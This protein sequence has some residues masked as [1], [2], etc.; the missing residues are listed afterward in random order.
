MNTTV[1]YPHI[2]VKL[3]GADG[4]A[5]SI[6]GRVMSALRRGDVLFEE[7]IQFRD[8]CMSGDYDHLLQTCMAWV[9][10]E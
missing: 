1:K 8:E 3:V 9:N 2:T 10:V 6:M 5:F 7:Q 4:N